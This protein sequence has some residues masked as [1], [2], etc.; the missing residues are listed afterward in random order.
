VAAKDAASL[1]KPCARRLRDW[2]SGR[3]NARGAGRTKELTRCDSKFKSLV[4]TQNQ[5]AV[6]K[7]H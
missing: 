3:K 7:Q 1:D 2:R 4:L 5:L 6:E